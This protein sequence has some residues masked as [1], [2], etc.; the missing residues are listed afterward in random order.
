MTHTNNAR[1]L[2]LI[3]KILKLIFPQKE[4][5]QLVFEN[6]QRVVFHVKL[7][8]TEIETIFEIVWNSDLDFDIL[9]RK[10]RGVEMFPVKPSTWFKIGDLLKRN[11]MDTERLKKWD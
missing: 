10:K 7:Y 5:D 2:Q 6:P 9:K 1:K 3:I 11:F 4:I 8:N